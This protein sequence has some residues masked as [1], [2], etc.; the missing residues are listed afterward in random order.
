MVQPQSN[1]LGMAFS[2]AALLATH[3]LQHGG[4]PA[5]GGNV[6]WLQM[7][8]EFTDKFNSSDT[9]LANAGSQAATA[10]TIKARNT[11]GC[12]AGTYEH[13]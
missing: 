3:A 8:E 11:G 6:D 9:S 5:L 7:S 4:A 13:L 12:R 10:Q 1:T 2:I